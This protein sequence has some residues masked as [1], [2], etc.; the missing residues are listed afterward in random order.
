[1]AAGGRR[2]LETGGG[3]APSD[4]GE[5]LRSRE[6]SDRGAS[7]WARTA[8]HLFDELR[9]KSG[10]NTGMWE[11]P[12]LLVSNNHMRAPF[13]SPFVSLGSLLIFHFLFF[14]SFYYLSMAGPELVVGGWFASAVIR[15]LVSVTRSYLSNNASLN[16]ES[17]DMLDELQVSL[18]HIQEMIDVAEQISINHVKPMS[19]RSIAGIWLREL[20]DAAHDAEDVL[21]DF[22]AKVIRMKIQGKSSHVVS[23]ALSPL[24][25]VFP[26]GD[27]KRLKDAIRTI[28]R[29]CDK[30]DSLVVPRDLN[31]AQRKSEKISIRVNRESSPFTFDAEVIGR[32]EEIS[33][34]MDMVLAAYS[35]EAPISTNKETDNDKPESSQR[36]WII[37]AL[38]RLFP[39]WTGES[40]EQAAPDVEKSKDKD[41]EI[42]ETQPSKRGAEIEEIQPSWKESERGGLDPSKKAM[43][44]R[45]GAAYGK[46]K[47]VAAEVSLLTSKGSSF[48]DHK[49][50]AFSDLPIQ[51]SKRIDLESI[52][53][54]IAEKLHG[55]PLAAKIVGRLLSMNLDKG[56]WEEV[57]QSPWWNIANNRMGEEIL[58][59]IGIGYYNLSPHQRQCFLYCSIFPRNYVF[60]VDKLVRMWIS[61]GFVQINSDGNNRM[62]IKEGRKWFYDLVDR[63]YLVPTV[64]ENRYMMHDLLRDFAVTISSYDCFILSEYTMHVPNFVRHLSIDRDNFDVQW[65]DYDREKL[66]T[67][68]TFGH[69]RACQTQEKLYRH[70]LKSSTGLRVLDLSYV[71]LGMTGNDFL[72][73]IGGLLH[74]RYL[75]LSFTG[76]SELP[77]SFCYLCHLQVLD[78]RGCQFKSL[79]KR[80]NRLIN[81]R[82]L[83]ADADTTAL[84][85]GIG[86]L[87]KLQELHEFRIKAKIGHRIS[88]LR[89]LRD[90]GGSLCISNL[91]MVADREESLNANLS[92]KHYLTSLDLR[93]ESCEHDITPASHLAME[94]LDGLRPSRTLEELK[95]S[96]Y[97]LSTFP[98][99]MGQLRYIRCVNIRNC[100]WLATL[101]PLGQLEH[102]QKLV[103]NYVPSITH[104]SSEVYG[105][106]EAI[107]RSLEA[108][109]FKLMDG[110]VDWEEA[111]DAV[112][113]APKL[114]KLK[115]S[116][117]L[118]LRR[119]PFRTLGA[120]VTELRLS[121]SGLCAD[122]ISSYLQRLTALTHLYLEGTYKTITLPCRNL[123]SLVSLQIRSCK[124]VLFKGGPLYLKNLKN[125]S[126]RKV[127]KITAPLDEEPSCDHPTQSNP[128]LNSLTHLDIDGLSLSQLLN[129]DN[130]RYKIPVLQTLKLSHLPKLTASLEMFLEQFTMLQQLEFHLCGELTRLPSNLASILSL[131]KLSLSHCPQIH[132]LPL[133]GL[134]G[135]LKELQIEGC[136]QMLEARCLKEPGEDWPKKEKMD[137]WRQSKRKEWWLGKRKEML[138]CLKKNVEDMTL[139]NEEEELIRRK[140]EEWLK[141]EQHELLMNKGEDWPKIAHI[142]Y[143]R[144]NGV[145]VQNLY[146]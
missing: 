143:I 99:W 129:L 83:Y 35:S 37:H 63:S 54:R 75:D 77:E 145:T 45:E 60:E 133:N 1:M 26:R 101:P 123:R 6:S 22:E 80:M 121:G 56:H 47:D 134:P 58:A 90:L 120:D 118:S 106:S 111:G 5:S 57:L 95:I 79:P 7:S 112:V 18:P 131:K 68:L 12:S 76:I 23:S 92:G 87:T 59:S 39:T 137:E 105:T 119:I 100:R 20:K 78:I 34:I 86:K 84:V 44:I 124:E 117:C 70:T 113:I 16:K 132:S 122:E 40:S 74:L 14:L 138:K 81:L 88:E 141:K 13:I 96:N 50:H 142:P 102:L 42:E 65:G 30:G 69:C 127:Q 36:G 55:L 29:L 144:V 21:D 116:S 25:N 104:V 15:N 73:G 136:S 71:S 93:F 91:L 49:R 32:D 126:V 146:L 85:Y 24:S 140:E 33:L 72:T 62:E 17:S 28:K 43:M 115:I 64:W 125:L 9:G 66:R 67:L 41:Q 3:P 107:F 53:R 109:S 135:S 2:T 52:G 10:K 4:Q 8:H 139:N 108:L 110:W 27:V 128:V 46:G 51:T 82:H 114:Q 38:R 103:L 94:I 98:D 19:Q 61:H 130:M 48:G 11:G 31:F 89:D 97:P